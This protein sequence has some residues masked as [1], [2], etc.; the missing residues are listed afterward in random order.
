[1][2]IAL[3]IGVGH[4]LLALYDRPSR[5]GVSLSYI[6]PGIKCDGVTNRVFDGERLFGYVL[7]ADIDKAGHEF[8]IVPKLREA[9]A[10]MRT[11]DIYVFR[12]GPASYHFFGTRLVGE[13]DVIDFA[14]LTGSGHSLD[15]FRRNKVM[16]LRFSEKR[17]ERPRFLAM[18]RD[19]DDDESEPY[20]SIPHLEFLK[21]AYGIA[22]RLHPKLV[23][24]TVEV[25]HY[26]TY[27][28]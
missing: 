18:L 26:V 3:N 8:G 22:P 28:R 24:G 15:Q 21:Q 5:K 13:K 1:V 2:K 11:G 14:Y 16:A 23:G 20:Y 6:P 10:S 4:A 12:T 25:K 7:F 19:V 27:D 17:G 9:R